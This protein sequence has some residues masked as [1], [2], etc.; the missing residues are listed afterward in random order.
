MVELDIDYTPDH[1]LHPG[2]VLRE[3]IEARGISPTALAAAMNQPRET[4]DALLAE[5][6][7]INDDLAKA[8]Q[9]AL[10]LNAQ[11]WINLQ[12]LHDHILAL[13]AA[14]QPAAQMQAEAD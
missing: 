10:G 8:I 14:D 1:A 9:D 3:E 11:T 7:P 5:Q 2:K 4:V 13:M 12:E 6:H